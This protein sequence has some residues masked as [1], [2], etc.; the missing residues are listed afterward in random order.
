MSVAPLRRALVTASSR[1]LG[2]AAA[3]ALAAQGM[4]LLLCARQ[5]AALDAAVETLRA[6]YP[7][8]R[9]EGLVCDLLD[10]SAPHRLEAAAGSL[11][12][13]PP[14][15]LVCNAGGP[16]PGAFDAVDDEA[17]HA[18]FELTF[19]VTARLLRHFGAALCAAGE[20]RVVTITSATVAR[21]LAGLTVSNALRPA[22][23]AL[24]RELAPQWAPFGVT[25]NNVAPGFTSTDR[26]EQLLRDSASRAGK[27]VEAVRAERVATIPAGRMARPEEVAGAVAYFCSPS[28][29]FVTGQ[30][31][32]VDGGASLA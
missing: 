13:A 16:A 30:T 5:G 9:F 22:V 32:V 8:Q 11:W 1:G 27:S 14:Q 21:P 18:G 29:G 31:L 25:I 10:R 4:E 28:A 15:V 19:L 2:F 24:V 3:E 12:S 7:H 23:T 26:V 20:G 17:W 6:A